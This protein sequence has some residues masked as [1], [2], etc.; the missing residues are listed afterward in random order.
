MRWKAVWGTA[1]V[2]SLTASTAQARWRIDAAGGVFTPIGDVTIAEGGDSADI[3]IDV[4]GSFAVGGGYGLGDWA[5][6]TAHFQGNFAGLSAVGTSLDVFSFTAGGRAYLLPP[7]RFRPWLATEIGW[8]R[9]DAGANLI[10]SSVNESE[11]SFGLNAG[12]GFDVA[13]NQRVSLGLD[14]RY[15][16]AFD[17]LGGVQFVTSMF[18]VGIHFG[19]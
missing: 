17:A 1:L 9:A 10:F 15:H 8:Y 19:E 18:N 11:D 12:A 4:G 5:D 6:V 14:V 13:L 7:Q 3:G 16:N 2:L